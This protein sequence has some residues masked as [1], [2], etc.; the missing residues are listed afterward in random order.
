MKR[1]LAVAVAGLIAIGVAACG[2]SSQRPN[3]VNQ[4]NG[5]S[6]AQSDATVKSDLE[7]LIN[8]ASGVG[9]SGLGW[10]VSSCA[11]QSGNQY[12]C[13]VWKGSDTRTL[14][15][16]D[17]GNNIYEQGISKSEVN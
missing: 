17:D 3:S 6:S 12:V 5:A 8:P 13:S 1:Y 14:D 9:L 2:G 15:V 7:G 10:Q 11:H 4:A 16:T